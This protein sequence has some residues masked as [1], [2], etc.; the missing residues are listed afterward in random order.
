MIKQKDAETFTERC[1]K[2][3]TA[4]PDQV[5]FALSRAGLEILIVDSER[6][7]ESNKASNE[8]LSTCRDIASD[9]TTISADADGFIHGRWDS[10]LP[11][12]MRQI[13]DHSLKTIAVRRKEKGQA[14]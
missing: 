1:R 6:Y 8:L 13:A 7:A 12:L 11:R 10:S 4:Q 3:L 14:C 9:T 5:E 2:M